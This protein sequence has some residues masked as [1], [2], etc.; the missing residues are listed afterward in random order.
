MTNA[1]RTEMERSLALAGSSKVVSTYVEFQRRL[2]DAN[3]TDEATALLDTLVTEM[4]ADLAGGDL[5]RKQ[6]DVL[7]LLLGTNRKGASAK[8]PS[9]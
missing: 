2:I 1:E 7:E 9:A 4:R 6:G 5:I 8:R 3:K